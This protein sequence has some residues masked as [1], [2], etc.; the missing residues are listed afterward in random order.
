MDVV[1]FV[2]ETIFLECQLSEEQLAAGV[3]WQ[4]NS[5]PL[6]SDDLEFACGP[7]QTLILELSEENIFDNIADYECL[8]NGTPAG[9]FFLRLFRKLVPCPFLCCFLHCWSPGLSPE[10]PMI[11]RV[12][13]ILPTTVVSVG[14]NATLSCMGRGTPGVEFTWESGGQVLRAGGRILD[15]GETLIIARVTVSDGG[16]YN[17]SISNFIDGVQ[18]HDS[19][20]QRLVVQSE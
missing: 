4:R 14:E 18:L 8:V 20:V 11:Q 1:G 12:C 2:G 13:D 7:N 17:C 16:L 10:L 15:D 6:D 19:Y 9:F 5:L 3:V